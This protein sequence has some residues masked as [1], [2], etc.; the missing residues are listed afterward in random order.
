MDHF[1]ID[2]DKKITVN[3]K[4]IAG[5]LKP[6][7]YIDGKYYCFLLGADPDTGIFGRGRTLGKALEAW[8]K[9]L[10][11]HLRVNDDEDYIISYIK[12]ILN[13]ATK[14]SSKNIQPFT[15]SLNLVKERL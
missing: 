3:L 11:K 7:I 2:Q 8:D 9:D 6:T 13:I 4:G 5:L 1:I 10:Q 15:I 12:N 14:D